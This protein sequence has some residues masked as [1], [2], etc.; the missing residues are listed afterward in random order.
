MEQKPSLAPKLA[1]Q[2]TSVEEHRAWRR[3][4]ARR[5]RTLLGRT[6]PAVP[7]QVD[8]VEEVET[9]TF[10]RRK[11][12]IRSEEHYWVPAYLFLPK[13]RRDAGPAIVC[14][15]GHSGI[16]PYI[17]DGSE[18]QRAKSKKLDLDYAPFFAENGYVTIAPVQRGW[19]E[20]SQSAGQ[21]GRGCQR[22]AMN[23]FLTGMTPVGLRGWDA[24]RLV[25]YL[26]TLEAVDSS[27]IGVAG[28]SGGGTIASVLGGARA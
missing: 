20:T 1:W 26:R 4:F 12:Y 28:L 22:L 2:A 25:D 16:Y 24:S 21:S 7:L 27:R 3:G 5:L 23:S 19:N 8:C 17:R 13:H 18:E 6:P 10:T 15:H 11:L 14:L 9:E